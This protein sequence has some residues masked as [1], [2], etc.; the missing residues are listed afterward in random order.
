MYLNSQ[1]FV[2]YHYVKSSKPSPHQLGY[3]SNGLKKKIEVNL[4]IAHPSTENL[5]LI[6][7]LISTK[8]HNHE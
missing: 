7:W 8:E 6:K 3:K 5:N 4:Q 1:S 2:S